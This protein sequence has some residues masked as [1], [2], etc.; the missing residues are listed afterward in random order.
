MKEIKG[1][2]R[3]ENI[4]VADACRYMDEG[5]ENTWELDDIVDNTLA[6]DGLRIFSD[7]KNPANKLSDFKETY[8]KDML[9]EK[10]GDVYNRAFDDATKLPK[11]RSFLTS[12][13]DGSLQ[14]P[15]AELPPVPFDLEPEIPISALT[16]RIDYINQGSADIPQLRTSEA[17]AA[18][19]MIDN[20][21]GEDTKI[22]TFTTGEKKAT[23]DREG[24]GVQWTEDFED[25]PLSAS[26]L[27]RFAAELGVNHV[28]D[29]VEKGLRLLVA[30]VTADT[31]DLDASW[32][33]ADTLELENIYSNGKRLN[34][35][36]GQKAPILGLKAARDTGFGGNIRPAN[37]APLGNTSSAYSGYWYSTK[38]TTGTNAI[39]ANKLYAL[40]VAATLGLILRTR[41]IV[42]TDEYKAQPDTY[43]RYFR[44][45]GGWYLQPEAP[46]AR[47]DVAA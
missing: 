14:N 4:S 44:R 41:D 17:K 43:V 18:A 20:P 7:S 23:M 12:A 8:Q 16:T 40:N 6:T 24:I 27:A 42:I 33:Y 25:S 46:I 32:T 11:H 45:K 9:L 31:L 29:M 21:E 26:A 35:I 36:F 10:C 3:S 1:V 38:A 47:V 28:D 2:C 30:S 22:V 39:A 37:D 5:K 13:A 34:A 19:R 15:S